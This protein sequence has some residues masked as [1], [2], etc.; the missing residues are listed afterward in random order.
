[1]AFCLDAWLHGLKVLAVPGYVHHN[2][3]GGA[4]ATKRHA[5]EFWEKWAAN[6][7]AFGAWCGQKGVQAALA[8]GRVP[9]G[10]REV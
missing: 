5:P 6:R 9:V 7:Q 10:A 2:I 1:M 8:D 4:G 3:V